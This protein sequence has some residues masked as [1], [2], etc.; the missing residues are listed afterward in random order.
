MVEVSHVGRYFDKK[1]IG[2]CEYGI[3][4]VKEAWKYELLTN[5]KEI[6]YPTNALNYSRIILTT[7]K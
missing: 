1:K 3:D 2:R 5:S 6:N 4:F 7:F